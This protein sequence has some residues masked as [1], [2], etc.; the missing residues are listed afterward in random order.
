MSDHFCYVSEVIICPSFYIRGCEQHW[1]VS[2]LRLVSFKI[3]VALTR[4]T[5]GSADI[6]GCNQHWFASTLK[7]VSFK[8]GVGPTRRTVGS[9]DVSNIGSF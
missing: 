7:L 5:V 4:R 2:R 8:I 3:G 6:R 1:F 9:A